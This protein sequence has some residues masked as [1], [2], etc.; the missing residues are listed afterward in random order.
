MDVLNFLPFSEDYS[1]EAIKLL[2]YAANADTYNK[3]LAMSSLMW[4]YIEENKSREAVKIAKN[5]LKKY[6]E[7]RFFKWGPAR[8]YEDINKEE[9]ILTYQDILNSHM[10]RKNS[11]GYNEI[12]LRHKIAMLLYSVGKKDAA[13]EYCREILKTKLTS[14]YVKKR[15]EDRLQRVQELWDE[16]LSSN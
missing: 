3:H 1:G 16:I 13:L 11:N 6:P 4:I 8:A 5:E 9:A 12:I 15:L 10:S 2:Q 7:S 14:E